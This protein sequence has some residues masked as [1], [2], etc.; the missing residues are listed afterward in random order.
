MSGNVSRDADP[1]LILARLHGTSGR[2]TDCARRIKVS[3]S[4]SFFGQGIDSWRF[5][6]FVS[7]TPNVFP[8]Q[9][10]N[11]NQN[12]VRSLLGME[13]ICDGKK[14]GQGEQHSEETHV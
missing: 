12:D 2:R 1:R 10:V 4:H 3:E 14:N 11:E 5:D 6:E 9:I 8:P 13:Y 7:V